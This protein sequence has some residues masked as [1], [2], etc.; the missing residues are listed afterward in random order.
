MKV[1]LDLSSRII[2]I[3][4]FCYIIS[5]GDKTLVALSFNEQ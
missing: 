4:C 5:Q 3:D 1:S 2:L